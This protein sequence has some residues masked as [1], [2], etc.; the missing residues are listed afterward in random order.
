MN[1]MAWYAFDFKILAMLLNLMTLMYID[2]HSLSHSS[3]ATQLSVPWLISPLALSSQ[4]Q[5]TCF[6]D[7]GRQK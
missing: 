5:F 2:G 4:V 6:H 1:Y 7:N 3:E